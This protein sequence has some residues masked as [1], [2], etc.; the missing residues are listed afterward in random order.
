[1]TTKASFIAEI[2]P[3]SFPVPSGASAW[4]WIQIAPFG[5]TDTTDGRVIELRK[6]DCVDLLEELTSR[7]NEAPVLAIHGKG[8]E[9]GKAKGWFKRFEIRDN[10]FW[11]LVEWVSKTVEEIRNKEWKYLSPS[12]WGIVENGVIKAKRFIEASLTNIPA[13]PGMAPVEAEAGDLTVFACFSADWNDTY[14]DEPMPV[15]MME[16]PRVDA[17]EVICRIRDVL[18]LP[19]AATLDEIVEQLNRLMSQAEL[20]AVPAGPDKEND[21]DKETLALLGLAEDATPE[22]IKSAVKV[23]FEA[24]A[25]QPEPKTEDVRGMVTSLV[26]DGLKDIIAGVRQEFETKEK[27]KKVEGLLMRV[28]PAKRDRYRALSEKIDIASFEALIA[29]LP[30]PKGVTGFVTPGLEPPTVETGKF[31]GFENEHAYC[32]AIADAATEFGTNVSSA[33]QLVNAGVMGQEV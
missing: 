4:K 32:Q 10:G 31:H 2:P 14:I 13:I 26:Q 17:E 9:G 16:G 1:M 27:A 8:P 25:K 19:V 33:I 11:G 15:P 29:E 7:G 28:E 24:K 6:E 3:M 12:F 20:S 5:R 18:R 21:M 22:Q 30:Q 23:Q